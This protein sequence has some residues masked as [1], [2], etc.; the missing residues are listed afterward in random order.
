[1]QKAISY[2]DFKRKLIEQGP[3]TVTEPVYYDI[4]IPDLDG[5]D[6]IVDTEFTVDT[7]R[8][9]DVLIDKFR[10]HLVL[11]ADGDDQ[12]MIDTRHDYHERLT[13]QLKAALAHPE[14]SDVVRDL[15][16]D[17]GMRVKSL[18]N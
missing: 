16:N 7:S 14:G 12:V 9:L 6:V 8:G 2:D 1:M 13:E 5:V 10:H 15:I 3:V 11:P 4:A 17:T 18:E